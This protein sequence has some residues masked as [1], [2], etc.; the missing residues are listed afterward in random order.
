[1]VVVKTWRLPSANEVTQAVQPVLHKGQPLLCE[2]WL[3]Q[4]EAEYGHCTAPN[5]RYCEAYSHPKS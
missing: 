5:D 3:S 2:E 4:L 1:M